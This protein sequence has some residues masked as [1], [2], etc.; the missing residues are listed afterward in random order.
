MPAVAQSKL[1]RQQSVYDSVSQLVP[2]RHQKSLKQALS[3]AAA[4]IICILVLGVALCAFF[5]LQVFIKPLLWAVLCGTFLFPFKHALQNMIEKWLTQTW[6][7]GIPLVISTV[8][9]PLTIFDDF[10]DWLGSLIENNW[11]IV[12]AFFTTLLSLYFL[13]YVGV[14]TVILS[15]STALINFGYIGTFYIANFIATYAGYVF[16][17]LVLYSLSAYVF[18]LPLLS[19]I[20]VAMWFF[21]FIYCTGPFQIP[22]SVFI[23]LLFIMGIVQE[24]GIKLESSETVSTTVN[25]L[26]LAKPAVEA[27][28]LETEPEAHGSKSS[29]YFNYLFVIAAV[30]VT[31]VHIWILLLISIPVIYWFLKKTVTNFKII[32]ELLDKVCVAIFQ[33]NILEVKQ[34]VIKSWQSNKQIMFPTPLP[35][36]WKIL[37]KGDR[38][39][40]SKIMS[41]LPTVSSILIILLLFF[42]GIIMSVFILAKVQQETIL[43]VKITT[44]LINETVSEH[45]EYQSWF[46]DNETM[47][48]SMDSFVNMV[49]VQG[50]EWLSQKIQLGMGP[51]GKNSKVEQQVLKLWDEFYHNTFIQPSDVESKKGFSKN[52]DDASGFFGNL[53][54]LLNMTEVIAW[55]QENISALMSYGETLLVV[56]QSNVALITSVFTTVFT[57]ILAGGTMVLNFLIALVVFF[58]TLFYLLSSSKNQYKP[59]EVMGSVFHPITKGTHIE[60]AI[61][62]AVN[63]VFGASLKMLCFYGLYTWV[64]H[65]IFGSVLVYIPSILAALFGVIPVLTT[66]WVSIPAA[67]EI[68]ILQD[69]LFRAIGLVVC[70]F[71]PT[72]IVDA[73]IYGDLSKTGG[74]VHPYVT[75]LAVAGGVYTFGLEGAIAGP[76]ILCLLLVA[77]NL[78][79]KATSTAILENEVNGKEENKI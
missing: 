56:L 61:A 15:A 49:Y 19:I 51:N 79:T 7:K 60:K 78:Y 68:W 76:L 69:S 46:P 77:V 2:A 30:I 39:M 58:T 54:D 70:Q 22:F 16:L 23:L 74:G 66:Y 4:L 33:T 28:K 13:N 52:A 53:I 43:V 44:N 42:G 25:E 63:G 14:L 20:S 26:H 59:V 37:K 10:S 5:V 36:L 18:A 57:T 35:T 9:L 50:R 34:K 27:R 31:W 8:I 41:Y 11:K 24:K 1:V 38:Y 40:H 65:C 75:G 32:I 71:L 21:G 3:T 48:R 72:L 45:P 12:S 29:L 17:G 64:N 62:D 73:A 47:H 67:L 55:L 6:N